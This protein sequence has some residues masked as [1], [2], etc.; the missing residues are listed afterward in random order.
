[1]SAPVPHIV[2]PYITADPQIADGEPVIA[3]TRITVQCI[4]GYY[5]MGMDV[6]DMLT[7]LSHLTAAQVYAALTYYCDHQD[8]MERALAAATDIAYWTQQVL[9]HPQ[10]GI[11]P[12]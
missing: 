11:D 3:G 2:Y 9:T 6:D 8:E 7:S 10:F 5:Q 12:S 4:A 1:M